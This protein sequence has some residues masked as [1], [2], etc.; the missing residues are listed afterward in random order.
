MSCTHTIPFSNIMLTPIRRVKTTGIQCEN[1]PHNLTAP[2]SDPCHSL[3]PQCDVVLQCEATNLIVAL[4]F[5]YPIVRRGYIDND[6]GEI[7]SQGK[8]GADMNSITFNVTELPTTGRT[9]MVLR[10]FNYLFRRLQ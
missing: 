10:V 3:C 1:V 9:P 4:E 5:N 6:Q 8:V 7:V 2:K